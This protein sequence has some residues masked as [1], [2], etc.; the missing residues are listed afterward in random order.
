M[1]LE[2]LAKQSCLHP[3]VPARLWAVINHCFCPL[4][5]QVFFS[6]PAHPGHGRPEWGLGD[7][8]WACHVL[9]DYPLIILF[10]EVWLIQTSQVALVVKNP[11]AVQETQ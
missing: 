8:C 11:P 1:V 10:T 3:S 4:V 7:L 9:A 6:L 2:D 5:L